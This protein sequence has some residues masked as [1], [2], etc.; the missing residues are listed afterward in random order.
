MYMKSRFVYFPLLLLMLVLSGCSRYVAPSPLDGIWRMERIEAAEGLA[1]DIPEG[2]TP[3]W[4]FMNVVY[5][6]GYQMKQDGGVSRTSRGNVFYERDQIRFVPDRED[7]RNFP[8]PNGKNRDEL[9][10]RYKV[11]RGKLELY[12]EGYTI[13]LIKR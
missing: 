13:Y 7:Q 3:Y 5:T 2:A 4:D 10:L 9:T 6:A 1:I 8:V 12:G 11:W